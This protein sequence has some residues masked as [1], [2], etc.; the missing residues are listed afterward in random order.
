MLFHSH[1]IIDPCFSNST[2]HA[3]VFQL[4]VSF[5]G[6][7]TNST[8]IFLWMVVIKAILKYSII[9]HSGCW[10]LPPIYGKVG[11]GSVI[12]SLALLTRART[13]GVAGV[14]CPQPEESAHKSGQIGRNLKLHSVSGML[15][16]GSKGAVDVKPHCYSFLSRI[17]EK[18]SP[19]KRWWYEVIWFYMYS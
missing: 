18:W 11:V 1:S 8:W 10:W 15:P 7:S 13:F 19:K 14:V 16:Q 17:M 4:P 5:D 9:N 3:F 12:I 6:N 2:F